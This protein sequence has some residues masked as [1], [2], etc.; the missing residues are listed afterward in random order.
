[1]RTEYLASR[2]ESALL[3]SGRGAV[4]VVFA[5]VA[6]N[7]VGWASGQQ[8]LTRLVGN[9]NPMTPWAAVL[10]TALGVAVLV[11]SGRPPRARVWVGRG[12][13]G[14]AGVVAVV[15]LAGYATGRSFAVAQLWFPAAVRAL[16][17]TWPGSPPAFTAWA[18]VLLAVAVGLERVDRRWARV[19][20]GMG[21]TAAAALAIV[22][23]TAFMFGALSAVAL[24]PPTRMSMAAALC[25]VLL[26]FAVVVGRPDRHPVSWLLARPDRAELVQLAGI[27]V[28][29]PVLAALIHG[30]LSLRGVPEATA[31]VLG[32]LI[33]SS[34]GA[35]VAFRLSE[36]ARRR[37]GQA[38]AQFR[39]I[40]ANAPIAIAVRNLDQGYEFANHAFCDLFG[41]TDPREIVGR[42]VDDL[43]L[44]RKPPT[45]DPAVEVIRKIHDA[46]AAA[47]RGEAGTFEQ[48][49][50]VGG[51]RLTFDVQL[52]AIR[53]E[54]DQPFAIGVIGTDVSERVRV[55]RA[56][57]E[58]L[59][60]EEFLSQTISGGRLLVYCQPIVDAHTGHLVEEELLVR[61]IGADGALIGP[62]GFLPQADR[63][64]LM[65]AIDRFMVA[66]GIELA[67]AGRRVAVNLSA[68]SINDA[69]TMDAIIEELRQAGDAAARMSFEITETTAV[70]SMEVAR[71]FSDDMKVLGC[72]VALDDFG[73]GYGTFTELR[74]LALH[75]LKIDQSFVRD[76]LSDKRDESV[77]KM[78][79]GI[80]KEFGLLTT[81]EGVEDADTRTRLVELGVDQ[82]QGYLIGAPQ[83]ATTTRIA[84][85]ATAATDQH[86]PGVRRRGPDT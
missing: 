50:T 37:H 65:A 8:H 33:A 9:W 23:I 69:D 54:R 35:A 61:M 22:A 52:F 45:S 85:G 13:A 72:R 42:S 57:R 64:G 18:V 49:L 31:W 56:L 25:V 14:A 11:Q 30:V 47:L 68:D 12:L 59:E 75:A 26:V 76:M 36:R 5:L 62:D 4:A 66:S 78:I 43:V 60:F 58:R 41:I 10:V 17:P 70:A 53:D 82:L 40:I 1:M 80:A 27:A 55:E 44:D 51:E 38:Q 28:W 29:A 24:S 84:T 39:S 86:Q 46:Q 83:P 63:F 7:W 21:L 19:V 16:D 71:R 77:V 3:R 15:F 2:L 73:T 32:L 48:E 6:A 20:W 74:G 67:R 34:V 81:A 79:I